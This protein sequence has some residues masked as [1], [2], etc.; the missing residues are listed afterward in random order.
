MIA[1]LRLIMLFSLHT[2]VGFSGAPHAFEEEDFTGGRLYGYFI[3][4]RAVPATERLV[5]FQVSC[6]GTPNRVPALARTLNT[7]HVML[8]NLQ[9]IAS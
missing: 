6:V 1:S 5:R 2:E 4:M 3:P 7:E 8:F 9:Y